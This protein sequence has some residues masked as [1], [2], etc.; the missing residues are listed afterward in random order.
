MPGVRGSEARRT[1]STENV[2][3][4]REKRRLAAAIQG[5]AKGIGKLLTR[6]ETDLV[7]QEQWI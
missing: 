1:P 4:S 3:E 7:R 6:R 5:G 2:L